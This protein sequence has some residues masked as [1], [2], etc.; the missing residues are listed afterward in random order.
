MGGTLCS[1]F[2]WE[3]LCTKDKLGLTVLMPA[4][5]TPGIGGFK[6]APRPGGQTPHCFFQQSWPGTAPRWGSVLGGVGGNPLT[7]V[8]TADRVE[9]AP[10]CDITM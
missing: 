3:T 2:M 6:A 7:P 1:Q 5:R 10:G 8:G 4:R 9:A